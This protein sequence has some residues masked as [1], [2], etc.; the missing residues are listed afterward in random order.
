MIYSRADFTWLDPDEYERRKA[1]REER[2]WRRGANQGELCCPSVILDGMPAIQSM[3]SGRVHDSKSAIRRE[4][5]A[6][7]MVE[8][9]NDS[10]L[11]SG[12][13][14]ADPSYM[15]RQA[16]ERDIERSVG[17]AFAAVDTMSD[18]TV[19]RRLYE[20]NEAS[21]KATAPLND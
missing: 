12:K 5:K 9:G 10:S 4:Y 15:E 19:K 1:D 21:A 20:R 2:A 18:E 16:K 17:C 7:G 11:T 8:V 6:H 3:A 14:K 13:R